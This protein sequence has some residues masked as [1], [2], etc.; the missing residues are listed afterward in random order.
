MDTWS[1]LDFVGFFSFVGSK[2]QYGGWNLQIKS[3][4][5]YNGKVLV[6][7]KDIKRQI[8][9][10]Y[11]QQSI[12]CIYFDKDR[13]VFDIGMHNKTCFSAQTCVKT[14]KSELRIMN[15][16][17]IFIYKPQLYS[18]HLF[19]Q[20]RLN[21]WFNKKCI[22]NCQGLNTSKSKNY[23]TFAKT[24]LRLF[25]KILHFISGQ[26]FYTKKRTI[27]QY[28]VETNM[29]FYWFKSNPKGV[30]SLLLNNNFEF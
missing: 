7:D 16:Y 17:W 3:A 22:G 5:V 14:A 28:T 12:A 19:F 9:Y 1:P 23:L 11:Y 24:P 29:Y 18:S 26:A 21:G 6:L 20:S 27:Y 15:S 8:S 30:C 13:L 2:V 10:D 25:S 4:W